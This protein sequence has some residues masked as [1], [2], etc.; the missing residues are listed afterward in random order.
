MSIID[1]QRI[2]AVRTLV[3]MGFTFHDEWIPPMG[4]TSPPATAEADALHALL[5]LRADALEEGCA[6]NSEAARELA[7]IAKGLEAT[8][9]SAGRTARFQSPRARVSLTAS[10]RGET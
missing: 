10:L 1:K 3:D 5:V 9:R 7:M 8:R 4:R 6:E 2:T